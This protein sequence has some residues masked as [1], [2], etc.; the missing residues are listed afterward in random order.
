MYVLTIGL[1]EPCRASRVHTFCRL[2][3]VFTF[4]FQWDPRQWNPYGSGV[5]K[6]YTGLHHSVKVITDHLTYEVLVLVEHDKLFTACNAILIKHKESVEVINHNLWNK[7]RDTELQSDRRN[8]VEDMGTV[9]ECYTFLVSR[10]VDMNKINTLSLNC[11]IKY[12]FPCD[13]S[14]TRILF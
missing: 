11:W 12:V 5:D 7:P 1:T 13:Y 8:L 14:T 3:P 4:I 2:Y 9:C 6:Y 10:N